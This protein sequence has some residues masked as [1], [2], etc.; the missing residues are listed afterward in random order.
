MLGAP[1]GRFL[2]V[3]MDQCKDIMGRLFEHVTPV[4]H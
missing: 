3:N 1:E 4:L 2:T